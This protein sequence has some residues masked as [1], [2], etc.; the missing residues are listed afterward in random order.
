MARL[1]PVL[2]RLENVLVAIE[3]VRLFPILFSGL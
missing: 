2:S 3:H 1:L